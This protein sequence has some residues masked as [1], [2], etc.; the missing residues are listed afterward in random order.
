MGYPSAPNKSRGFL[1]LYFNHIEKNEPVKNEPVVIVVVVVVVVVVDGYIYI[2]LMDTIGRSHR[3]KELRDD[4]G[5]GDL[6]W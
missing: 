6:A 5:A 3:K 2:E 4:G 1:T